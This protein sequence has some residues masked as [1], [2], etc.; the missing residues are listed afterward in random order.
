MREERRESSPR[1]RER[2][3]HYGRKPAPI[4]KD[5]VKVFCG[6]EKAHNVLRIVT[7][8]NAMRS[9]LFCAVI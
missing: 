5:I 4:R 9:F 8:H 7:P 3:Q 6:L 1:G 2:S